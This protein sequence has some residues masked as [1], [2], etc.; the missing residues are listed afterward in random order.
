LEDY[1]MADAVIEIPAGTQFSEDGD[2]YWD[3]TAWQATP[4]E[5]MRN[6]VK[7]HH[8]Q[9]PKEIEM[10]PEGDFNAGSY[11]VANDAE[12]RSALLTALQMRLHEHQTETLSAV[13]AFKDG[14]ESHIEQL[15]DGT[16]SNYDFGP[17]V[18]AVGTA[19]KL[20]FPEVKVVSVMVDVISIEATMLQMYNQIA[21]TTL[22]DAK[23]RL[24]SSLHALVQ[25][26][27]DQSVVA[28]EG[29]KK[30]LPELVEEVLSDLDDKTMTTNPAFIQAVCDY[31]GIPEATGVMVIVRQHLENEFFGVYEFVR[32]DLNNARA[33]SIHASDI[34]WEHEAHVEEEKKF[35]ED[36][37]KA[38]DEVYKE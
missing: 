3:G 31:A 36:G 30:K 27:V 28:W 37:K 7:V 11:P 38:W 16:A 26:Y 4:A 22:P 32:A 13:M 12:V 6:G 29:S 1:L 34:A 5:F 17:V 9:I 24:S 23:Q 33:G 14:A 21:D 19:M 10:P 2:W 25:S 20:I 8:G 15:T 35:D 18:S